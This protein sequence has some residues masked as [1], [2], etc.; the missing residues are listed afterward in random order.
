VRTARLNYRYFAADLIKDRH[1]GDVSADVL[2]HLE[3]ALQSI[4]DDRGQGELNRLGMTRLQELEPAVRQGIS[5][6]LEL[7]ADDPLLA[8]P[9]KNLPLERRPA[10]AR[11]LGRW[12]STR[13]YRTLLLHIITNFWSEYLTQM[14]GLRTAISLESYAQRDP[15]VQYKSRASELYKSLLRDIRLEV[16][17]RVFT[18]RPGDHSS[19]QVGTVR[20][21][22]LPAGTSGDGKPNGEPGASKD[23]PGQAEPGA[24]PAAA[25]PTS[26]PQPAPPDDD[27]NAETPAP[28]GQDN[29]KKR[30]RYR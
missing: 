22:A 2:S 3:Q 10:A 19:L 24:P 25:P 20:S 1:A 27:E 28:G 15:L 26:E 11:V 21:E 6:A 23:E 30:K 18:Y 8:Q 13:V 14:E 4:Q 29:R 16:I 9:L 12:V 5:Q 17:T 7:P